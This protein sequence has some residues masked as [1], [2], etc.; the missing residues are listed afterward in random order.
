MSYIFLS[1][2]MLIWVLQEADVKTGLNMQDFI[3]GSICMGENRD[4]LEKTGRDIRP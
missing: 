4:G 3:K 1:N 2:I